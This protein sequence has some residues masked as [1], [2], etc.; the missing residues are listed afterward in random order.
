MNNIW[1]FISKF[2]V[3]AEG[4]LADVPA[5]NPNRYWDCVFAC[6][7]VALQVYGYPD[8][9][10]EDLR[11]L[12]Q[13]GT[14]AGADFDTVANYLRAHP[15]KWPNLP[16]IDT[17]NPPDTLAAFASLL[18]KG[19]LCIFDVYDDRNA[20]V[21]STPLAGWGGTHAVILEAMGATKV[22]LW[23]PWNGEQAGQTF[24]RAYIKSATNGMLAGRM[25]YVG[26]LMVFARPVPGAFP[27]PVVVVPPAV[28]PA[29][30]P[31]V[32][33]PPVI[34]PP[35]EPP[36]SP[37]VAQYPVG[38]PPVPSAETLSWIQAFL[39]WLKGFLGVK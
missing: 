23:N 11:Q 36:P 37:I 21:R 25:T 38:P 20:N 8:T 22:T 4:Q 13:P 2:A 33:L 14:H 29:T 30:P 9:E 18:N 24:E 31:V 27:A 26:N 35:I 1:P 6:V 28:P 10:P 5:S 19:Y 12:I 15:Q 39:T 16:R 17:W 34:V 3:P 32:T 7:S